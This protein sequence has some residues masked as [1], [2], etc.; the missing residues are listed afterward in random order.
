[1]LSVPD[2]NLLQNVIEDGQG[3]LD[4]ASEHMSWIVEEDHT[5]V[6]FG[7]KNNFCSREI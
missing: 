3:I 5:F 1:M 2:F 7:M 6:C 4:M